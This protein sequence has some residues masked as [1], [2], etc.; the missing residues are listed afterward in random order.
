MRYMKNPY[1]TVGQLGH[2]L[3]V[4]SKRDTS[5]RYA[6]VSMRT[7]SESLAVAQM[8]CKGSYAGLEVI[9]DTL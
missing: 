1:A 9:G 5:V 4:D 8:L 6:A 2:R 3:W 7:V